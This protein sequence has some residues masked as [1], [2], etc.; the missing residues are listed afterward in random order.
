M[1]VIDGNSY[2]YIIDKNNNKYRA[3]IKV[4]KEKLPFLKIN[5]IVEVSY[6]ERKEL[7][8]ILVVK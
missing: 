3:N 7:T 8:E 4:S 5:D 1:V 2:Y 6:K